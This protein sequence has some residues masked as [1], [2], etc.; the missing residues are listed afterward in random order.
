MK[1]YYMLSCSLFSAALCVN[2]LYCAD[3]VQYS[4][5]PYDD[6][7]DHKEALALVTNHF[8]ELVTPEKAKV[9]AEGL[10]KI[11]SNALHNN[12]HMCLLYTPVANSF[13]RLVLRNEEKLV[14]IADFYLSKEHF[15]AVHENDG[16]IET[17]I[18]ENIDAQK[19]ALLTH[20]VLSKLHALGAQRAVT[21]FPT[22]KLGTQSGYWPIVASH[23]SI[24]IQKQTN[25]EKREGII[26][27]E[28]PLQ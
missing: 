16:Y 27:F 20:K 6:A 22:E 2:M 15:D 10:S 25:F 21:H 3:N 7:R 5:L 4:V 8:N 24:K 17:F 18:F 28:I 11:Y 1:P 19:R 26:R 23:R 14:G 13:T 12:T 9:D